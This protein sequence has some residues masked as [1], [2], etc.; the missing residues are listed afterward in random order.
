MKILL[1]IAMAV[2]MVSC[3]GASQMGGDGSASYPMTFKADG[4]DNGNHNGNDG[5]DNGNHY[6]NGNDPAN[7]SADPI[8]AAPA[9]LGVFVT[10]T[11]YAGDFGGIS[12][13][14]AICNSFGLNGT[15]VAYLSDSGTNAIDRLPEGIWYDSNG[16][17]VFESKNAITSQGAFIEYNELGEHMDSYYAWTGT[18]PDGNVNPDTCNDWTSAD[19]YT[20]GASGNNSIQRA[21]DDILTSWVQIWNGPCNFSRHLY[22]FQIE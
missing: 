11:S 10:S 8:A 4:M 20:N 17:L 9:Q 16:N 14:D 12:N 22:C 6:G 3:G 15:F 7:P 5:G 13:G 18:N 21:G 1:A 19:Q 2:L